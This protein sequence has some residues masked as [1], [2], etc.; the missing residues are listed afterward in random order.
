MSLNNGLKNSIR[1]QYNFLATIK[2]F[3]EISPASSHHHRGMNI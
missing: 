2:K 1:K 3:K